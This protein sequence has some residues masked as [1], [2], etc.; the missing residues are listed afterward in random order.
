MIVD[1]QLKLFCRCRCRCHFGGTSSRIPNT[2]CCWVILW[3]VQLICSNLSCST[4]NEMCFWFCYSCTQPTTPP[5]DPCT[6]V[7]V[8]IDWFFLII[9]S[10]MCRTTG[11]YSWHLK[12]VRFL[13]QRTQQQGSAAS[14]VPGHQYPVAIS[15]Q[16][17]AL[18]TFVSIKYNC[19]SAQT[20]LSIE[21]TL[22]TFFAD[23]VN[24]PLFKLLFYFI[25]FLL[26][27]NE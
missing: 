22:H 4:W 21:R 17:L 24:F 8:N 9:S 6:F 3:I 23:H 18:F 10:L 25:S 16:T 5:S 13:F 27:K 20:T 2:D 15:M 26:I 19:R 14:T 1:L 12:N 11:I 7:V